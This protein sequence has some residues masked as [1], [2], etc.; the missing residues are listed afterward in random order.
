MIVYKFCLYEIAFGHAFSDVY[1]LIIMFW[2]CFERMEWLIGKQ[3]LSGLHVKSWLHTLN[4]MASSHLFVTSL[5]WGHD[6][7]FV[8]FW[9]L[10][11]LILRLGSLTTV[12][13]VA[14]PSTRSHDILLIC[15]ENIAIWSLFDPEMIL[16]F[17]K[18][19]FNTEMVIYCVW[20]M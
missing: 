9:K 17:R 3:G 16:S 14:T 1:S 18:F 6:F 19:V 15:F 20:C 7:G 13:K 12:F 2:V 8:L 11:K 5:T 4:V 10:Y